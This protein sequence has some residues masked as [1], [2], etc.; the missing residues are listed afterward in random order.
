M[1]AKLP[2]TVVAAIVDSRNMFHQAG[3]AIGVRARPTVP[4]VRAALSRLGFQVDAVHVGLALA[5]QRDQADLASPHAANLAYQQSVLADGGD[6]LLGEL[7]RKP[8]GAVEEKMVDAACCVRITRYVDEIAYKR[9]NVEAI[10]VLSQD[11]DLR[12][13]IDYAV[14]MSVPIFA[15]ALDVVQHRAHPFVLMGPHAYAEMTS[16]SGTGKGHGLRERLVRALY[17]QQPMSWKVKGTPDRPLLR[18]SSGLVAVPARRVT[19]GAHGTSQLLYPVDVTW[20]TRILGAFPLLVCDGAPLQA[21]CWDEAVVRRR[22]APMTLEIGLADGTR[23]RE[24]FPLGGVVPGDKV[25]LHRASGRVLGRLAT[26][27]RQ[28]FDPDTPQVLRVAT[29]L[30]KGG[31]LVVDPAGS[32]GFLTTDQSLSPGQ[33]I[34][35]IQIDVNSRGAVWAAIG[36]PLP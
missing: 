27:S 18:H 28:R 6:V 32:R 4:G 12:P 1:E 29:P 33:R 13:A 15:G 11:I 23:R 21:R 19:L 34:P 2:G 9:T 25:L 26:Q 22:T 17:D 24:H 16:E 10:V 3:D 31:A 20:D 8:G 35:A 7:H 14:N 5:R 36:T 30:P